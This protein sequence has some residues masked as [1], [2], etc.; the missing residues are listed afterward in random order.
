MKRGT[1][2]PERLHKVLARAGIGSRRRIEE[3]IKA[4]RV[5]ING[6]TATVGERVSVSDHITLDGKRINL[7]A[8]MP[9]RMRVLAYY[10]PAGELT[11]REDPEG[12][13]TVFDNLPGIRKGRWIAVGRLD[14]NTSGLLL[15]TNNGELANR[16]MHPSSEV[17][18]EYAVRILGGVNDVMINNMLS[19]VELEDGTA[20]LKQVTDAGGTGANHWYRVVILEGRNREVRRLF[21]SQGIKVSR[22]I[23]VRFGCYSLPKHK[24][25]GQYWELNKQEVDSLFEIAALDKKVKVKSHKSQVTSH[26]KKDR[27]KNF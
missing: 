15:F 21:E 9:S 19:G 13:H 2:S 18:R 4:G 24:R 7:N 10:K 12:R 17:E 1:S 27:S 6:R 23:R 22:L 3:W 20:R 8:S 26:K 11:T 16:L 25:Q 5:N 14:L